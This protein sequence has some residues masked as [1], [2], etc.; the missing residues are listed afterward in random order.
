MDANAARDTAYI[1]KY[2]DNILTHTNSSKILIGLPFESPEFVL[3]PKSFLNRSVDFNEICEMFYNPTELSELL[4]RSGLAYIL[5]LPRNGINSVIECSRSVANKMR[6][7][8][9]RGLGGTMIS[10]LHHDD[11]H[12]KCGFETYTWKNFE[13]TNVFIPKRNESTFPLLRTI[14]EAIAITSIDISAN[15]G[16]SVFNCY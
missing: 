5:A 9:K 16:N 2:F 15:D 7:T 6:F 8:I 14:N 4:L 11:V 12:G 10:S 13:N 1:E 3:N